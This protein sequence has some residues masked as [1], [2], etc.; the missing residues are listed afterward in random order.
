MS[1]DFDYDLAF[2]RNIGWDTHNKQHILRHKRVAIAGKG[3]VGGRH[4]HT[5]TRLGIGAFNIA[6]F[7]QFE[8]ANFN[9]QAGAA[10][11]TLDQPKVEVL[12]RLARDISPEL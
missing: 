3:G 10:C 7:D 2:S 12:A 9:R 5:L 1:A 4:Q 8:L 11:S 6:D